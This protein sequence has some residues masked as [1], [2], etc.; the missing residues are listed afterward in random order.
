MLFI[1]IDSFVGIGIANKL[2]VLLIN[3]R[4][5]KKRITIL[6]QNVF[7]LRRKS[8]F[9]F[10]L[11]TLFAAESIQGVPVPQPYFYRS[12]SDFLALLHGPTPRLCTYYYFICL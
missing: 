1:S 8:G 10:A 5:K 9:F 3:M 7:F 2:N 6:I 12:A 11:E 4:Q